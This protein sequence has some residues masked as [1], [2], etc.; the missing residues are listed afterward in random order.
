MIFSVYNLSTT[1]CLKCLVFGHKQ[2]YHACPGKGHFVTVVTNCPIFVKTYLIKN[3]N[4]ISNQEDL[5]L[6]RPNVTA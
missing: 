4:R 1:G 6:Q 5:I 2:I 3:I